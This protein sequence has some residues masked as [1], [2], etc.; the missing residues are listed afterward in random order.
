MKRVSLLILLGLLIQSCGS[1]FYQIKSKKYYETT[2]EF[3]FPPH[4]KLEWDKEKESIK[5]Q[6]RYQYV[7]IDNLIKIDGAYFQSLK[8]LNAAQYFTSKW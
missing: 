7:Y 3:I 6:H 4:T 8:S 5:K 2:N 1:Q